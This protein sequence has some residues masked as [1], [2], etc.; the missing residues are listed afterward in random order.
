[1][2]PP[3]WDRRAAITRCAR[4]PYRA[5]SV[6]RPGLP[7]EEELSGKRILFSD[8]TS[9]QAA[10]STI[11]AGYRSQES[12]GGDFRQMMKDPKVVSFA[13]VPLRQGQDPRLRPLLRAHPRGAA[14]IVREAGPGLH[15][16]VRAML[17]SLAG[18]QETVLLYQG[19]RGRPRTRRMLTEKDA[20][21]NCLHGIFGLDAYAPGAEP[22]RELGTTDRR[23]ANRC[24]PGPALR[25]HGR[26]APGRSRRPDG[27][28]GP[29][30]RWL[31]YSGPAAA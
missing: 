28:R 26:P 27:D 12:G 4:T 23:D 29:G 9:E 13:D 18:I 11:I 20:T 1:M 15:L 16:S 7:L 17:S 30:R 3:R 24:L 19:G 22:D 6:K 14:L 10:T 5:A 8:K 31:R 2:A 25:W 21:Q